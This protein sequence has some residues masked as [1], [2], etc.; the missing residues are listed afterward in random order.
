MSQK[1]NT[2]P[3]CFTK[4]RTQNNVL[5]CPECGYKLCDHSYTYHDSYS[6]EHTHMPDYTTVYKTNNSTST[7]TPASAG[8]AP[9]LIDTSLVGSRTNSSSGK[10]IKL[11]KSGKIAVG[12]L[13]SFY[14]IIPL[15]SILSSLFVSLISILLDL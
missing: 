3:V 14:F 12:L 1:E 7:G 10:G 11:T 5:V 9:Q 6:T 8:P 4:M 13:V 15:L 2:C